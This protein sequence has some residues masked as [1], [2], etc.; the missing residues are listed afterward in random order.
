MLDR[1]LDTLLDLAVDQASFYPLMTAPSAARRMR[2]SMGE[3]D[4]ALRYPMYM[5]ILDR[6]L[7]TCR[8]ASAW[9][10]S[11]GEDMYDEYIVDQDDYVGVGSGAFSYVGGTMYS[12][13]FS[14]NHY[15]RR[16]EAGRTGITRHR[17]GSGCASA[18]VTIS[19]YAC[20]AEDSTASSSTGATVRSSG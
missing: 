11:R 2:E 14:L 3:S 20:S 10:F 18:C 6:L 16:V 4:P 7:P 13:T 15:W 19:W 1:D 8:P 12:T 9:C 5:R 17:L